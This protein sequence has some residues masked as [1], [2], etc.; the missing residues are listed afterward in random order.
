MED[1][2]WGWGT[3]IIFQ[4]KNWVD[5]P[6]E[7]VVWFGD[8]FVKWIN[9]APKGVLKNFRV[10]TEMSTT[11]DLPEFDSLKASDGRNWSMFF[12]NWKQTLGKK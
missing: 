7:I 9:P 3:L 8:T 1:T 4:K 12:N 11:V 2:H 10:D 6:L 5:I